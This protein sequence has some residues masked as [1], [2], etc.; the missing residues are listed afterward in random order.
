MKLNLLFLVF[1]ASTPFFLQAQQTGYAT[2]AYED[3]VPEDTDNRIH[4]FVDIVPLFKG[5]DESGKHTLEK[6]FCSGEKTKAFIKENLR[7]PTAAV[8]AGISG[9]VTLHAIIEKNGT[10]SG[11]RII[12][13]DA[14]E[15]EEEAIRL[16]KS[17]PEWTPGKLKQKTVR[18]FKK[19]TIEF[20][21]GTVK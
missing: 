19:M 2:V 4:K 7:Y 20:A 1:F 21:L 8:A 18:A 6:Q 12:K 3:E 9:K 11:A 10:V 14:K 13:P 15:L 16:V 5:C 17:M